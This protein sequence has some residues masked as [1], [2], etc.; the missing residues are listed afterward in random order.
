MYAD[1]NAIQY[2]SSSTDNCSDLCC[3][4]SSAWS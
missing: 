4:F 2:V 3:I 1:Q